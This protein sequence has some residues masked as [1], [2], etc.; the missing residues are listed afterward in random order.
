MGASRA[1]ACWTWCWW[2]RRWAGGCPPDRCSPP[3]WWPRPWPHRG[4]PSSATPSCPASSR[5]RPS[6]PGAWPSPPAPWD[7][8]PDG[9]GRR[10]PGGF[11]LD[12]TKG[13]VEAAAEADWLLV[14]ATVDGAPTHFLVD[15]VPARGDRH[16][17]RL[18]RPGPTVR[19]G[20]LRR[21]GG[22]GRRRWWARS[23][24]RP[25]RSSGCSR[26]PWCSSARRWPA[27]RTGCSGVTLEY[28]F[29]RYSFGRPLASYQA[30]KHRFADLKLWVEACLATAQS[31]ARAVDTGF[32]RAAELVSVAKSYIGDRAPADPP[33]LRP[34]PGRH[35]GDLGPRPAPLSPPGGPGPGALRDSGRAPRADRRPAWG[36][37][38]GRR[39]TSVAEPTVDGDHDRSR[40][41][42]DP[43]ELEE[44]RLRARAF[45]AESMPR[46]AEDRSNF[47]LMRE[48]EDGERARHLQKILFDGGLR[49]AVL[50]RWRTGA[51][52]CRGPTSRV[53]P[54]VGVLRDADPLQRARRSASWPPPCWT[55][56]P[57]SRSGA[58]SRPS[59][60]GPSCGCSSCRSPR[61]D[62]TWPAWSPGPPGTGTSSSSTARRSGARGPTGP[63]TPCA[64]PAPTSTR[65]STGA[66]PASS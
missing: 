2:P 23:V 41:P 31:A 4:P 10:T 45:L 9:G 22:A 12:G 7:R 16:P 52:D 30:L 14:A 59:S 32:D 46:L 62:R 20:L 43:E 51:R 61:E 21:G 56:G 65:P 63:T 50:S 27:P 35:R 60:R 1:T 24:G 25:T 11:V 18:P 19:H 39:R 58:T 53:H 13:P 29:D 34:A 36:S 15:A 54:G 48:D 38:R 5:G 26:W 6:P 17:G 28:A 66:S 44:F 42:A 57:R 8:R 40:P 49:R 47:D 33:G 55:S 64:W 37:R 3:I